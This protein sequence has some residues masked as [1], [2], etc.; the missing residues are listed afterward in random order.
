V[1]SL[2][3]GPPPTYAGGKRL[4]SEQTLIW[5]IHEALIMLVFKSLNLQISGPV[6]LSPDSEGRDNRFAMT[7]TSKPNQQPHTKCKVR[8]IYLLDNGFKVL[9]GPILVQA[10][11]FCDHRGNS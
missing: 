11:G 6:H 7:I 10:L 5:R 3:G 4:V 8:P 9:P 1:P 2:Q